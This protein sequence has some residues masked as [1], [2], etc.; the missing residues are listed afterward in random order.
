MDNATDR[1][2]EASAPRSSS[3][4]EREEPEE[5]LHGG[6]WITRLR[7]W[8]GGHTSMLVI[9]AV[10]GIGGGLGA[11]F[12]RWLIGVC[13]ILAWG[14]SETPLAGIEASAWTW[15]LLIPAGGGLLV[16]LIVKFFAPEAKGHG[17]PEV[18]Y[19][20]ARLGGVI[21][22]I[23]AVAKSFAS[24]ICIASGGS[25]GREGPIVQIGS[26]M[27]SSLAQWLRLSVPRIRICVGCGA[28]AGIAA[29]FNAPIAGAFFA[30]EVILG[31][32]SSRSF[33]PV[34]I[35]SVTAT[36]ISRAF[37]GNVPAFEIPKY[38]LTNP[39][40]LGIYVILGLL[41]ALVAVAFAHTLYW[42]EDLADR[43]KQ[44]PDFLQPVLG[45][46][47]VGALAIVLPEVMGV[48]Y[49]TIT[50]ALQGEFLVGMLLAILLTKLLAT[51]LTLGSGGSG[52]VFAPSL[53]M[54]ASLGGIVGHA[55]G[56]ILPFSI[57]PAGAYA[58]VGMGAMVSA[59]THAPITA[60]LI[61]FELTNDYRVILALMAS[62][63]LSHVVAQRLL[64]DS[65][66]TI[67]LSRRGIDL[68]SGHEVNVLR[69]IKVKD[70]VRQ[71]LAIVS[72]TASLQELYGQLVST[73]HHVFFVVD[74]DGALR[75]VITVDDLRRTIPFQEQL[76]NLLI[77]E[78]VM[79]IPVP[80]VRENDDLD[81]AMRQ[82]GKRTLEEL[83]VLPET[84]SMA[85]VGTLRRQDVI[86]AYNKE[87]LKVDLGG[88]LSSRIGAVGKL[89]TWETVGGYLLAHIEVPQ[90]FWG[91]TLESLRLPKRRGVQIILVECAEATG[92][93]CYVF[94]SRETLFRPGDKAIVFGQ[95]KNVDDLVR[96]A[97]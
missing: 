84:G 95:R 34:V 57:S 19:A 72:R 83:P 68:L 53:F 27:A 69:Q 88:S 51:S 16:G 21:R 26:A 87:I 43:L 7:F 82:F 30:A 85:P 35:S 61:I 22:P 63:I 8:L 3:L 42:C 73:H 64:S 59:T 77:A 91:K 54:G 14:A 52:G 62:C 71:E 25:V 76:R 97:E 65:I 55:A 47:G 36:A 31:G 49:D 96:Q 32:F 20:T 66:Y 39:A 1:P 24:A 11:I 90:E 50:R 93:D 2:E 60:M 48:G 9:A 41:C 86:N 80:F 5:P 92:D 38:S 45:G 40:E 94:P 81:H 70:I 75:G 29:T 79:S 37:L 28:A 17:V 12:F 56:A 74:D 78:D 44:V 6:W 58:V 10:I 67:K 89:R 23:V 18:M 33:G 4:D 15:R 13:Q 46:L